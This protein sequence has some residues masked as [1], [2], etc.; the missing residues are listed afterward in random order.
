MK[1]KTTWMHYKASYEVLKLAY[2][3][4]QSKNKKLKS[5]VKK[6]N[7][8]ADDDNS[9]FCDMCSSVAT[10]KYDGDDLCDKCYLREKYKD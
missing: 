2:E 10:R 9:I 1:K 5:K 3:K 7:N 8:D 6:M 4:L